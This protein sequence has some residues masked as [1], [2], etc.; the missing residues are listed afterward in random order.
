MG[1]QNL[2]KWRRQFEEHRDND[3][4]RRPSTSRTEVKAAERRD[5]ILKT[6]ESKFPDFFAALEFSFL[7]SHNTGL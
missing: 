5:W 7:T 3:R 4:T 6:L 2:R 1:V